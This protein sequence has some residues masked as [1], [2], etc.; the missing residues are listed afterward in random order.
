MHCDCARVKII[1]SLLETVY[2]N[3]MANHRSELKLA[4]SFRLPHGSTSIYLPIL[5][6]VFSLSMRAQQVLTLPSNQPNP[7]IAGAKKIYA[8]SAGEAPSGI[9]FNNGVVKTT[10]FISNMAQQLGIGSESTLH[11]IK[12]NTDELGMTHH[13]F[14]QKYKGIP[15]EG[16]EYRVHER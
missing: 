9:E 10:D 11:N 7:E 6:M 16:L 8:A 2:L 4:G 13:R 3:L 12:T 14:R 1:S 15:V 5:L